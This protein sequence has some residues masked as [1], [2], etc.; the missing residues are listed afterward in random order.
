M[1]FL[2]PREGGLRI[3]T[4]LLGGG[5]LEN[6]Q[7]GLFNTNITPSETDTAATYTAHEAVFANYAR[8]T[9]V[10]SVSPTTWNAPV[11]Q[12]PSGA[13]SWS[14]RGLVGCSHYG[15]APQTWTC[16]PTGDTAHGYFIIGE[17]SG[18]LI[19]A[20]RFDSPRTLIAGD[21]LSITPSFE[22]A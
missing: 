3:L 10:R 21:T 20:E 11:L 22:V 1:P 12:T 9:L 19:L 18:K 8:K 4:D 14:S 15:S 7:L 2:V 6:W 16:G 17:T 5:A 13:P